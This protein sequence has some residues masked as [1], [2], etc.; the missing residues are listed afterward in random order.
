MTIS[1]VITPVATDTPK[2]THFVCFPLP[3]EKRNSTTQRRV[4]VIL[5]HIISYLHLVIVT[6]SVTNYQTLVPT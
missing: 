6:A 4:S 1:P 3:S 5:S 2:T